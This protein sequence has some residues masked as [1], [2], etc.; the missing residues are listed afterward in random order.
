[1]KT[2]LSLFLAI[3]IILSSIPVV[4]ASSDI[5]KYKEAGEIL[6]SFGVLEGSKSGDLMLDKYL[7][8]QDMVV[9]ISRLYGQENT[10]KNYPVKDTFKD[11]ADPSYSP[12]IYWAVDQGLIV[13]TSEKRFGYTIEGNKRS[14]TTVQQLQTVLLKALGYGGEI[15]SYDSVPALAESLGIMK[16]LSTN[17]N[18]YVTRGL[19]A[20]MT[21]NALR[22]N[23]KGSS[24]TLSKKLNMSVPAAASVDVSHTIDGS[25]LAF[26]GVA[27]GTDELK[28]SLKLV[29]S[30]T[31][32]EQKIY[33]IELN[34]DGEFKI[35]IEDIPDGKYEYNFTSKSSSL[36][37]GT[38]TI[39]S[40]PIENLI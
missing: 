3:I 11:I 26:K 40:I 18:D 12:Y 7:K 13:G 4:E 23:V 9:L 33:D 6:K 19:M 27:K 29:S 17:P 21:L 15:E 30:E 32:A 1:M 35:E 25:T 8:R 38:I 24:G 2:V 20:S 31:S 22:L 36:K 37:T 28:L 16:G 14:Y 10:A 5:E 34:T 39:P